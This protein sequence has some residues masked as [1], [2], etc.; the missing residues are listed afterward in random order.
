MAD[1]TTV[2]RGGILLAACG[3]GALAE[4]FV[5]DRRHAALRR[6]TAIDRTRAKLR[7][8][9]RRAARRARYLEGVGEGLAHKS[10]HAMPGHA[11]PDEQP[12]D[13]TLAQM[14][15]SVAF[16]EA[17]VPKQGINVNAEHGVVFLR[18]SVERPEQIG[19]LMRA[20]RA[21]HGVKDVTSLLHVPGMTTTT[22]A[23]S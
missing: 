3:I 12:D 20:A 2:R 1:L 16:R 22:T 5:F 11:R 17:R 15:E 9:T 14:V 4:Y 7:R 19:D 8:R 18:G 13:A 6:H 21:V 23:R 10:L